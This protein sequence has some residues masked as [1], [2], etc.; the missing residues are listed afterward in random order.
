MKH[1]LSLLL[2]AGV[3]AVT[4]AEKP[5]NVILFLADDLGVTDISPYN[6]D[7]FYDTPA[8]KRLADSGVRFTDGYAASP[9]CSPTRSAILTGQWP[10]RTRNTNYFGGPNEFFGEALPENYDPLRDGKFKNRQRYPMLPAPYLGQLAK[11][12]TTLAE[13]LKERGYATFFA[14]KW[15]LGPEGSWPTDHGFDHNLG[16]HEKGGT[17]GGDRYFSP[18]GNPNLPDGPKGEHLPDRLANETGKFI[19]ENKDRPF[20]AMLSFYSV[21]TPL[22]G[23]PD[24]VEKYEKRRSE[25]GLEDRFDEEPPRKNRSVQSHAV[26]AAMVEAM[27]QAVGKVLDSLDAAGVADRTL[28]IFT[29]DNG[30][31]STSEGSPTSN[32]PF[33][34]GKGWLY[35]GGVREP[36]I[37]RWPGVTAEGATSSWPVISTD[38][39]PT[40]LEAAGQP[41]LPEQHK[42]GVS[43]VSALKNPSATN[44]ERPLYFH[45]PHWGNQ[46]G[47]PGS[48]VRLGDW[49][50]IDWSWNKPAELFHLGKDPGERDNVAAEN[51]EVVAKMKKILEGFHTDTKALMPFPNPD[52]K[53]PFDKW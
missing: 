31:L 34:A 45:F 52:A 21:H 43:F 24:L 4:A 47:I 36:V 51:P 20:F 6:P 32:L 29:S 17:Y 49:K 15:H 28:V 44:D 3:T 22:M 46:G 33:R 48:A 38:F 53:K 40:I 10:A 18:Y 1:L 41:A 2:T 11:A 35:E 7:A 8:L 39:F 42:D 16:G 30:G 37:V 26:Y 13:A 14:G 12:H 9:V 25:R 5:L 23:R 50:Y 27:D 19:A